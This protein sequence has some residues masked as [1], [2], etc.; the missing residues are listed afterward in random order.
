MNINFDL[1]SAITEGLFWLIP[2]ITIFFKYLFIVKFKDTKRGE[3]WFSE[4]NGDLLGCHWY[5]PGEGMMYSGTD[6]FIP[7]DEDVS[8]FRL[9]EE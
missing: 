7:S 9:M 3:Y 4:E 6:S 5:E 8:E 2:V 1:G